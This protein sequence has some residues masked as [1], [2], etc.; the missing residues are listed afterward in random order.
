V[1][2]QSIYDKNTEPKQIIDDVLESKIIQHSDLDDENL[3]EKLHE[4]G[5]SY[6]K[7]EYNCHK[8]HHNNPKTINK[9][10]S[11]LLG[12]DFMIKKK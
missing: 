2:E 4:L 11:L 7:T 6:K 9:L 10:N 1:F 5:Q 8:Q 12:E 3:E